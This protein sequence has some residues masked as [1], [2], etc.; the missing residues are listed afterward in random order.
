MVLLFPGNIIW[1]GLLLTMML[2]SLM[3]VV[4]SSAFKSAGLFKNF[5]I[6]LSVV[7]LISAIITFSFSVIYHGLMVQSW[8]SRYQ[9]NTQNKGTTVMVDVQ[10][11]RDEEGYVL[12]QNLLKKPG[13]RQAAQ[14]L[15]MNEADR[16]P[17]DVSHKGNFAGSYE[18]S[19]DSA[20]NGERVRTNKNIGSSTNIKSESSTDKGSTP[21]TTKSNPTGK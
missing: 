15:M 10:Y 14:E 20:D 7:I 8:S 12:L 1:F 11:I 6:G 3:Y 4:I 5:G 9:R 17:S 19:G 18:V 16:N 2:F 21:N 13:M